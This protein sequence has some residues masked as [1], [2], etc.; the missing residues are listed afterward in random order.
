[1]ATFMRLILSVALF[2]ASQSVF[3]AQFTKVEIADHDGFI[4]IDLPIAQ[5]TQAQ[6]LVKI[7][8]RGTVTGVSMGFEVDFPTA[9]NRQPGSPGQLKP[10]TARIRSLGADSNRFVALLSR[11]YGIPGLASTMISSVDA[12]AAGL[13]DDSARILDGKKNMKFFFFDAGPEDRY[14][15]VYINVDFNT[16]VLEFHEKDPGYRKTLLLALTRGIK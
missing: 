13:G 4:D 7:I 6:G 8:A 10:G 5:V 16:R 12:L 1:M 15:E 2:F 14:A 9:L 11:R 3:A